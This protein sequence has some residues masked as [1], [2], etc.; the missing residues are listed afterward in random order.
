MNSKLVALLGACT[1]AQMDPASEDTFHY[2]VQLLP[3]VDVQVS[4]GD[5]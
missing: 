3:D 5:K 1:P 4:G 2:K